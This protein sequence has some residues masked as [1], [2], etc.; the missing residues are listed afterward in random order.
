MRKTGVLRY[1]ANTPQ[2]GTFAFVCWGCNNIPKYAGASA[3]AQNIC[4]KF[5]SP[6]IQS[7]VYFFFLRVWYFIIIGVFYFKFSERFPFVHD[8]NP[9]NSCGFCRV[10]SR[11]GGRSGE[12]AFLIRIILI[13][14]FFFRGVNP[15]ALHIIFIRNPPAQI[16]QSASVFEY[17]IF[18]PMEWVRCCA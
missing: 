3:T 8:S 12:P 2:A 4:E 10:L 14:S 17:Q 1:I 9:V 18:K 13:I 5:F 7:G 11:A 15:N 16:S 6:C